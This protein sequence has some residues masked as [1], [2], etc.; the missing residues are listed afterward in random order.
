LLNKTI[1]IVSKQGIKVLHIMVNFVWA[2][3]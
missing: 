3:T 2:N 1:R